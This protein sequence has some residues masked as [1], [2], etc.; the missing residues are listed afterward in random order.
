MIKSKRYKEDSKRLNSITENTIKCKC[1]CSITF[2]VQTDRVICNWCGNYVY[3]TPELE[4]KYKIKNELD[5]I[6]R[7]KK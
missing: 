4:F 5:K 7:K 3:R 2:C 1:G 6:G